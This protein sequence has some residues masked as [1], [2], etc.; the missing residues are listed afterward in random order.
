MGS[1]N[2]RQARERELIAADRGGAFVHRFRQRTRGQIPDKHLAFADVLHAV[3]PAAAG[4]ADDR[5]LVIKTVKKAVRR[6]IIL[7]AAA[8]GADPAN[9]TRTDNGVQRIV[10]QAVSGPGL[11]A[12]AMARHKNS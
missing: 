3:F 8:P 11:V 10:G 5:R 2:R 4:K 12:V 6:K 9:R 1:G 7:A